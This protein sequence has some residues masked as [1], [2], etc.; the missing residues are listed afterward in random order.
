[1]AEDSVITINAIESGWLEM[2]LASSV[3]PGGIVEIRLPAAS[4]D[5]LGELSAIFLDIAALYNPDGVPAE[6]DLH[7]YIFWEVDPVMYSYV[8]SPGEQ[9]RVGVELTCCSDIHA[10]IHMRHDVKFSAVV[11]FNLLVRNLYLE[12][13]NIQKKYGLTGYREKWQKQDFP[14]AAFLKIYQLATGTAVAAG[15][16]AAEV[17]VLQ[18]FIDK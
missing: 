11:E 7:F 16:F 12:M 17:K 10:G 13:R 18:E 4:C 2:H 5:P 1:M 6:P 15:D 9:W 14:I 3:T 8:F